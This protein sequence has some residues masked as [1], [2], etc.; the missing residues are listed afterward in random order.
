LV[1]IGAEAMMQT[2]HDYWYFY[3]TSFYRFWDNLTPMEYGFLLVTV[4][5]IGYIA[6]K[7]GSR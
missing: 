6:M 7:S 4:A 3:E 1:E 2:I 5:V